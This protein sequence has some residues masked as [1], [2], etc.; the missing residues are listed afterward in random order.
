MKA[1]EVL[2]RYAQG[3][4]DFQYVNIKGQSFKGQNLSGAD[5]SNADIRGT[6]FTSANLQGANFRGAKAGL[7]KPWASI[8]LIIS[9]LL[10]GLSGFN[11]A[12]VGRWTSYLLNSGTIDHFIAGVIIL[13]TFVCFAIIMLR[14]GLRGLWE[15]LTPGVIATLLIVFSREGNLTLALAVTGTVAATI[16]GTLLMAVSSAVAGVLS[17]SKWKTRNIT[18]IIAVAVVVVLNKL[19]VTTVAGA[20]TTLA[21]AIAILLLGSYIGWQALIGNQNF[22]SVKTIAIAFAAMRGTKF[23]H[24]NLTNADFT[25]ATVKN[26]DFR[27]AFLIRTRF[28]NTKKL[29]LILPGNTYLQNNQIRQ[30]LLTGQGQDKNFN[31]LSL[32][33]INL[34]GANLADASFVA[35]DLSEANLQDADL[36]RAKLKQTQLDGTDFTGATLT[37]SYIEDWGITSHTNFTGVRCEYVYM[38]LPTKNNP[39]PLRKP[40]NAAEIFADGEFGDFIKPIVDTLDLYHNQGVDP[41]AIAISFKELAENNPDTELEIVGMEVRGK[42]K[43]LLRA[44]TALE[45]DKSKL[46]A[47]YFDIYNQLKALAEEE[48]Q[49]LMIEKENRISSLE[50][51]IATAL[52]RP[53]FYTIS[54]QEVS[55]QGDMNYI[56]EI[57]GVEE[58]NTGGDI[59]NISAVSGDINKINTGGNIHN[60]NSVSGDINKINTG[61]DIHN[62]SSVSRDINKINT[63]GNVNIGIISSGNITGNVDKIENFQEARLITTENINIDIIQG[64]GM[65]VGQ[66]SDLIIQLTNTTNETLNSLEIELQTSAQYQIISDNPIILPSIET[67]EIIEISFQLLM[68][69]PKEVAV[70]YKINNRLQEAPIYINAVQDNPYVYGNPVEGEILF[71]GRKKELE[72]IIQAVTK[73]TKQDILIIGERRTGKTSLL[74]QVKKRLTDSLIPVYIVLNTS[75]EATTESVLILILEQIIDNL[76]QREILNKDKRQAD[77]LNSS[78][79]I[80]S[81]KNIIDIARNKLPD[82]KIILL[83]DEADY[84]L[85]VKR[86]SSD[87]IDDSLQNILRAALQS[88]EVGNDLRAIVAAT[89]ELSTYVSQRSSPFFNHFRF[90]RLRPLSTEETRDLIIKPAQ[91]LEY[92]Y[93]EKAIEHIINSSGRQPYYCQAL[94]YESF[95][96]ALELKHKEITLE[97]TCL[98]E[99]KIVEDFFTGYLSGFWNKFNKLEKDFVV[100]LAKGKPNTK[101]SNKD[102]KRLLD[103]QILTEESP[104][105]YDFSSGL[106]KQWTLMVYQK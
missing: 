81:L 58:I 36:S 22:A 87:V 61:G 78:N 12:I 30:L 4:R 74:N 6:N 60:I 45:V 21:G 72:Q 26:T 86:N 53:N 65:L 98:A 106:I 102:I 55:I 76:V 32:R 71:F 91:Q 23:C 57:Q 37:G 44:K 73:P 51:M 13:I 80:S 104:K 42:D 17:L 95:S 10:S 59:H 9:W 97:D 77:Y 56:D 3:E 101:I 96:N 2:R 39:D 64:S 14:P 19:I 18:T 84:L 105:N 46:S 24:A 40:D 34:Q 100:A 83:I 25:D 88:S 49:A 82:I 8:I 48:F 89:T 38:R 99:N 90:L 15:T 35:A 29:D 31:N 28:R 50:N 5:F 54:S 69:V 94:C 70:S 75:K 67:Q 43:F 93:E 68:K 33:G 66:P 41:R 92:Q 85:Q 63:G 1:S 20:V 103:W 47:E 62:I 27:G 16:A 52:Q 7:Q 11:A 79:F